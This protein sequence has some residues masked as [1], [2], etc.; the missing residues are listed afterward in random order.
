MAAMGRNNRVRGPIIFPPDKAGKI[1]D[2]QLKP[3]PIPPQAKITNNDL[4]LE[5]AGALK[6]MTGKF[7]I[8]ELGD[9]YNTLDEIEKTKSNVVETYSDQDPFLVNWNG[10]DDPENPM[11]FSPRRMWINVALV[12]AIAFVA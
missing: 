6:Q 8:P 2:Y 4:Y 5:F 1:N 9:F 10:T 12:S 11:N 3:S 7:N